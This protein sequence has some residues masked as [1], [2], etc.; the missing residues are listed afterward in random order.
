MT[1]L[2][3]TQ[4]CQMLVVDPKTLRR[5]LSLAQMSVLADPLDARVKCLTREQLQQL[6]LAH[7]RMLSLEEPDRC[8]D[9]SPCA[10]P[11]QSLLMS[12]TRPTQE[13]APSCLPTT[14][15]AQL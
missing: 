2:S 15:S 14:E 13:R 7:R 4:C 11:R 12:I 3:L 10:L 6:A 8:L 5:W 1:N 9:P